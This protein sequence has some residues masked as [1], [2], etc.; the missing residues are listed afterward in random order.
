[1]LN[2][3]QPPAY[4]PISSIDI[5]EA[6]SSTLS[7]G[8]PFHAV[9]AGEQD[10]LRLE[11]VFSAGSWFD[12]KSGQSYFTTKM[13]AEGT[14]NLSSQEINEKIDKYGAFLDFNSG[15]D[16]VGVVL[17]TLNKYLAQVLPTL[18]EVLLNANFPENELENLKN[19]TSQSIKVNMEKESYVAA[20]RFRQLVFGETHAYGKNLE[21]ND[22]QAI[23]KS[24][25]TN[26][27]KQFFQLGNAQIIAA[28]KIT[29]N[30]KA[31]VNE[32]FGQESVRLV[33]LDK[34]QREFKT[35]FKS[36][37]IER[38]NSIQSAIR[39]GRIL[40]P[41]NHPDYFKILLTNEILGGYFGSRLMQNLREDKGLT[42]GISS[43]MSFMGSEGFF[44]IGADVKKEA[45]TQ[46]ID[47]I[48]K[49]IKIMQNEK[50]GAQELEKVQNYLI[51]SFAASFTTSFSLADMFGG[52]HFYNLDY[53]FYK[54]Y[55]QKVQKITSDDI[56]NT[57]QKYLDTDAMLEIV[58][59]GK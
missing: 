20:R 48:Y 56:I 27:F 51:G 9:N 23:K 21:E 55:I 22:V 37:V 26:F 32:H 28:G 50:V 36:E 44:V 38:P 6:Q 15:F 46:A 53:D 7:N 19:R 11:F 14:T 43:Q 41:K 47:E 57:A 29:D 16:R 54:K 10:L 33:Q 31:L 1:M 8:I 4:Q 18:K 58:V 35:V 17:Y 5:L 59:G 12:T 39:I 34:N 49:E 24:D 45:T 3:L 30:V 25:L 52:V 2:R 13:L 40:F 42:Y